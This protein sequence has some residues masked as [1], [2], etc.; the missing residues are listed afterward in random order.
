MSPSLHTSDVCYGG[1]DL[2][3]SEDLCHVVLVCTAVA[4]LQ[5]LGLRIYYFLSPHHDTGFSIIG[6]A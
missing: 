1:L 6:V 5:P 3:K 2:F 4:A